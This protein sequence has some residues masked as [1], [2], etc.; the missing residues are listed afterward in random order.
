MHPSYEPK[1]PYVGLVIVR[2]YSQS[3]TAREVQLNPSAH[4]QKEYIERWAEEHEIEIK[5]WCAISEEYGRPIQGANQSVRAA[6]TAVKRL[7]AR[8]VIDDASRLIDGS[9]EDEIY[10]FR[11]FIVGQSVYLHSAL[12]DAPVFALNDNKFAEFIK[13][14][15]HAF[16][17]AERTREIS[18]T[19]DRKGKVPRFRPYKSNDE[20]VADHAVKAEDDF[21]A[22]NLHLCHSRQASDLGEAPLTV[23][24]VVEDFNLREVPTKRGKPWTSANFRRWLNQ[25]RARNP[26]HPI[27][28]NLKLSSGD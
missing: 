8:A 10:K 11:R 21:I 1:R 16:L 14:N 20:K 27:L 4:F 6:S 5:R 28:S 15:L 12:Q 13:P 24:G 2:G 25:F 7:G 17:E 18:K 23:A 19:M 26:E 22:L 9:N 3:A